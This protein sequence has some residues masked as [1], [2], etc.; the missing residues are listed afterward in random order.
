MYVWKDALLITGCVDY[1]LLL[2][3]NFIG[4]SKKLSVSKIYRGVT[5]QRATQFVL[6]LFHTTIACLLTNKVKRALFSFIEV[7]TD[8]VTND[9]EVNY[10]NAPYK[11][12]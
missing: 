12:N 11:I 8:V 2:T 7:F 3:T 9:T 4:D 5:Q 6:T 10:Y 1:S